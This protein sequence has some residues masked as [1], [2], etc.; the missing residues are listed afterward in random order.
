[1]V[2]AVISCKTRSLTFLVWS[3]PSLRYSL[4]KP[5]CLQLRPLLYMVRQ[6]NERYWLVNKIDQNISRKNLSFPL[7]FLDCQFLKQS[8]RSFPKGGTNSLATFGTSFLYSNLVAFI[9]SASF[10]SRLGSALI[11]P[12]KQSEH[13][14]SEFLWDFHTL[15]TKVGRKRSYHIALPSLF[16]FGRGASGGITKISK[17]YHIKLT[18]SKIK[19]V[20]FVVLN[21]KKRE[22]MWSYATEMALYVTRAINNLTM[23]LVLI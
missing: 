13:S 15:P 19:A 4:T 21:C 10:F 14:G 11:H 23:D 12:E 20:I 3:S 22:E 2:L 1:M 16:K 7:V 5:R 18:S 9:N 8:E 17:L 6:R